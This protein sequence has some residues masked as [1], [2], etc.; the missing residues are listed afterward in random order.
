MGSHGRGK[1]A[2]KRRRRKR[3][4]T[5]LRMLRAENQGMNEEREPCLLCG[6][7]DVDHDCPVTLLPD[8]EALDA[9]TEV[10]RDR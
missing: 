6:S 3:I 7:E 8:G 2:S 9:A 1:R 5:Y 10:S 4:W